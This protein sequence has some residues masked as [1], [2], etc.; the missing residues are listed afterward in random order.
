[1]IIIVYFLRTS[2]THMIF[3]NLFDIL[4]T[5]LIQ[6]SFDFITLSDKMFEINLISKI[7]IRILFFACKE[8]LT[9]FKTL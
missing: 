2:S 1:M 8:I 5:T 6:L 7:T 9:H 3:I 4:L